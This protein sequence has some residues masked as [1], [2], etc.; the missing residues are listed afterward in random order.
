M[1]GLAGVEA[2]VAQRLRH[3]EVVPGLFGL[4]QRAG[5][6][7][8]SRRAVAAQVVLD[9]PGVERDRGRVPQI[10]RG[11]PQPA[12]LRGQRIEDPAVPAGRPEPRLSIRAYQLGEV[13][14]PEGEEL[15]FEALYRIAWAGNIG[16]ASHG[17]ASLFHGAG[18]TL[19]SGPEIFVDR[20][21]SIG[22]GQ[23]RPLGVARRGRGRE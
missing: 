14:V 19:R 11:L 4:G 21:L 2:Q 18:T 6:Q 8:L 17:P 22:D 3:H 1:S 7:R 12:S 10:R 15:R 16:W 20:Y 5:E 13:V 9:Q 23:H